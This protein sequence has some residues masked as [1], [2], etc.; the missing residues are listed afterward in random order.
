[1]N[2]QKLTARNA[3]QRVFGKR[4]ESGK[5]H[6]QHLAF[7]HSVLM[8]QTG[9]TYLFINVQ[10][11]VSASRRA[12]VATRTIT[13]PY[14]VLVLSLFILFSKHIQLEHRTAARLSTLFLQ[15][16]I[17]EDVRWLVHTSR[18]IF[19][20]TIYECK[21]LT[22]WNQRSGLV[23]RCFYENLIYFMFLCTFQ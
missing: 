17:R 18:F 3:I 16:I 13:Y 12:A 15:R 9:A 6:E 20:C 23:L 5:C 4:S 21:L 14:P 2:F 22:V 7:S 1:M 8:R 11:L 10:K 19:G